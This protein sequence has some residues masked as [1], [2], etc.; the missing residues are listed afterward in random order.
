MATT[1]RAHRQAYRLNREILGGEALS[2][3]SVKHIR[4]HSPSI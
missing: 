1:T 3:G 4:R 2:I